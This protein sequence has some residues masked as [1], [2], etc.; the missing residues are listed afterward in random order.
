MQERVLS[1]VRARLDE[2]VDGVVDDSWAR[3]AARLACELAG[4]RETDRI[5]DLGCGPGAALREAGRRGAS[6]PGPRAVAAP[7][8]TEEH[9]P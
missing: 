7:R 3:R 2:L 6:G 9:V 5:V 8:S 4:I 1:S